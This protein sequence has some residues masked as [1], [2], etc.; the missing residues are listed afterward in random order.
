MHLTGSFHIKPNGKMTKKNLLNE[1]RF[2]KRSEIV[3]SP[4]RI[5]YQ[6]HASNEYTADRMDTGNIL[7]KG[8][9]KASR[10]LP[11]PLDK[12]GQ[13]YLDDHKPMTEKAIARIFKK[14]KLEGKVGSRAFFA[15]TSEEVSKLWRRLWLRY[16]RHAVLEK[17]H[18]HLNEAR[19][20][21]E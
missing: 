19:W 9:G 20:M 3:P 2:L 16:G 5:P 10:L 1:F 4:K 13:E 8:T 21:V 15:P 14:E 12:H 18:P 11:N 7:L 17:G 6:I